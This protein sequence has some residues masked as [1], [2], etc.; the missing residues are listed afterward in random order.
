[1]PLV[2]LFFV[3]ADETI[4]ITLTHLALL[5]CQDWLAGGVD[6]LSY[7]VLSIY[8]AISV[9]EL[10]YA[11]VYEINDYVAIAVYETEFTVGF[12]GCEPSACVVLVTIYV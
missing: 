4:V 5:K 12:P 2:I 11:I 8:G 9:K 6:N 10:T 1:M 7:A 3:Y